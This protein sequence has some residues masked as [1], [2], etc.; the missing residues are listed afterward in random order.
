MCSHK[1]AITC[2][3]SFQEET[4]S[5]GF[6]GKDSVLCYVRDRNDPLVFVRQCC[7]ISLDLANGCNVPAEA[8]ESTRSRVRTRDRGE[9]SS[10][11]TVS[12]QPKQCRAEP[13]AFEGPSARGWDGYL[14]QIGYAIASAWSYHDVSP[15][16][17]W[18]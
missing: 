17:G 3:T 1:F 13:L 8:P 9:R 15:A 4:E 6:M 18:S 5:S 2:G 10:A 7:D 12:L 16:P 14:Q 11:Q